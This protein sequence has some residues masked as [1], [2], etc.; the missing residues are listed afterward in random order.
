VMEAVQMETQSRSN[1]SKLIVHEDNNND[2]CGLDS[3]AKWLAD[4]DA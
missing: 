3:L 2:R 4:P 1:V